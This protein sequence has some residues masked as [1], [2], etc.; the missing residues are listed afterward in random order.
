MTHLPTFVVIGAT[1]CGTTSLYQYLRQH[2]G[3][4]LPQK[5]ELHY[6][7]YEKLA[8]RVAGPGDEDVVRF[9]CPT[10]AD[11]ERAFASA[12]TETAL[13][14]M[15]PSYFEH[16]EVSDRIR[17]ELEDPEIVLLLR[18]PIERTYSQYMHLVRDARER[19]PFPD[20]LDAE[21]DRV[22]A[23]W[24]N[25]W[26]YTRGSFYSDRTQKYL[27]TFGPARMKVVLFEDFVRGPSRVLSEL[28]AFLGVD[29]AWRFESGEVYNRSGRPHSRLVAA[30]VNRP[31]PIV[32]RVVRSLPEPLVRGAKQ[33][34]ARLNVGEKGRID[35]HSR[36]RLRD[37][38]SEDVARL[39]GILGRDLSIWNL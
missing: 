28:C 31:G 37:L 32:K 13:G 27:D 20:A 2:P 16:A 1:K 35:A 22:R 23:G 33:A 9:A 3:I 11:Y 8:D 14:D 25:L 30:F 21:P 4:F 24:G 19:L 7:T 18:N 10:R 38:F 34:I 5:K 12:T 26:H 17:S 29:P 6:F 36:A 39:E 15:S